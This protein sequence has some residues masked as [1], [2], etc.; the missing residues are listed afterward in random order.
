MCKL[1]KA[2]SDSRFCKCLYLKFIKP[3]RETLNSNKKPQSKLTKFLQLSRHLI[4]HL[5]RF[6]FVLLEL[7]DCLHCTVHAW[8]LY[9]SPRLLS[10]YVEL[11]SRFI[12]FVRRSRR[13][14]VVFIIVSLAPTALEY[15]SDLRYPRNFTIEVDSNRSIKFDVL[16]WGKLLHFAVNAN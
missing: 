3:Q 16:S 14:S 5:S 12:S 8:I 6:H 1:F 4:I 13:S 15:C 2:Q 11:N 7:T 9:V 10:S